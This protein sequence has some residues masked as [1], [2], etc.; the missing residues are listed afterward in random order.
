MNVNGESL[1]PVENIF[2]GDA[3][4][5]IEAA[6]GTYKVFVRNYAYH[7]K[8]ITDGNPVPWR[9]RVVMN[10]ESKNY[11][12]ECIG[13]G[14]SSDVTAVEFEYEGRKVPLPE[15]IGSALASSNLVSITSSKGDTIE[16]LAELSSVFNDHN[17]LVTLQNLVQTVNEPNEGSNED[18]VEVPSRLMAEGQALNITNRDRLYLTLSKLPKLFHLEV[19]KCFSENMTLME[20]AATDLAK[21]LISD[22]V[23]IDELKKAGYQ[24][25]IIELV[26]EKMSTCGI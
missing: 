2:F 15:E 9:I 26:K 23:P 14:E 12:G 8:E 10:G 18:E 7:G 20:Y 5:G 6:K 17:Q 25:D 22:G 1:E 11:S 24:E 21:R 3:E 19:N 4:K 16:S 13:T